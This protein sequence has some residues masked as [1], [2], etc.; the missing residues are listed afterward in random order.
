MAGLLLTAPMDPNGVSHLLKQKSVL[1]PTNNVTKPHETY[2]SQWKFATTPSSPKKKQLLEKKE[3]TTSVFSSPSIVLMICPEISI[4]RCY[5]GCSG[6]P[7]C[8]L[9]FPI[10]FPI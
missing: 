8:S 2:K 9:D 10:L 4:Y 1:A 3:R 6:F 5:G 7:L